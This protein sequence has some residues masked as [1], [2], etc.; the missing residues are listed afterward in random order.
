VA[1]RIITSTRRWRAFMS[2][3]SI[4]MPTPMGVSSAFASALFISCLMSSVVLFLSWVEVSLF[5][6][7][8]F[9]S[10]LVTS[11]LN[12]V[13]LVKITFVIISPPRSVFMGSI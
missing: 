12:T 9:L 4:V 13:C 3:A 8:L 11:F 1:A 10:R 5:Q 7:H 2:L 6:I